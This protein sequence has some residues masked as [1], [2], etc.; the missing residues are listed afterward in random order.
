MLI[1]FPL[2]LALAAAL[3]R[4]GTLRALAGLPVRGAGLFVAALA[5]Q[6]LLYLPPLRGAPVTLRQGG[7]LYVAALGL[8]LLGALRNWRLGP[9]ARLAMLGLALNLV[10]I[11]ANGGYMPVDAA[12]MRAARGGATVREIADARRYHNV[13]LAGAST[14][15]VF[16][17]DIIP[18]RLPDGPGNVYSI[19]DVLLAAG[20]AALAYTAARRPPAP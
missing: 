1:T 9:A 4:G 8:A 18:L 20:V 11:A 16:L 3:L 6:I 10:A 2:L 14:R 12:A 19:G 15:L 13:R 17:S 7:I 5:V